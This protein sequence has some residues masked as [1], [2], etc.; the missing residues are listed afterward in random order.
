MFRTM[1][2]KTT[3]H[4]PDLQFGVRLTTGEDGWVV[5][6]CPGLPGC[7]SQGR[8]KAEALRNIR[9]AIVGWLESFQAHPE[10]WRSR[11]R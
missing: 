9:E 5:V 7:I 4:A 11:S 8:T 10:T 3:V 1:T 6:E 2:L